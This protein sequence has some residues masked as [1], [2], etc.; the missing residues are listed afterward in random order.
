MTPLPIFNSLLISEPFLEDPEFYRT[1]IQLVTH[2]EEGSVGFVLN[3][4]SGFELCDLLD[5]CDL[6]IPVF[7]GG[8]VQQD[9]LHFIHCLSDIPE[10]VPL[11]GKASWSG[12]FDL[13]K[14]RLE[15][16]EAEFNDVRFFM[17][18]SGWSAGQLQKE[19]EQKSWIVADA[20]E[21]FIFNTDKDL[22][23]HILMSI[24]HGK[25]Q[26]LANAPKDIQLN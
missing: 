19:L 24:D 25:Y 9:T 12:N 18:Y 5:H 23:K 15:N 1:V 11:T 3:Q 6:H 22:W 2:G 26:Y 8:P 7:V 13:V 14:Q 16:E 17:G 20:A 21:R 4:P 10:A